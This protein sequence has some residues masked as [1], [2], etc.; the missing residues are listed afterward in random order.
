MHRNIARAYDYL[1]REHERVRAA[2][3]KILAQEDRVLERRL[4][5]ANLDS[6]QHLDEMLVYEERL[7]HPQRRRARDLNRY[8]REL[9]RIMDAL[10]SL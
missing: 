3:V 2:H 6:S 5:R 9:E 1:Q 7:S 4:F 8:G 10:L